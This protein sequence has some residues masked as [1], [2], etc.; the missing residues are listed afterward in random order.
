MFKIWP[1][2]QATPE[3][4]NDPCCELN[5]K[6]RARGLCIRERNSHPRTDVIWT[7]RCEEGVTAQWGS[8]FAREFHLRCNF[9]GKTKTLRREE[10]QIIGLP[11]K[12]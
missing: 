5:V 3:R 12:D 2:E 9:C 6:K 8:R 10:M 11:A 4:R 1:A 7:S